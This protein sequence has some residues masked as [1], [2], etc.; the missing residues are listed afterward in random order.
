MSPIFVINKYLEK[1]S[2]LVKPN[3]KYSYLDADIINRK[4]TNIL[5]KLPVDSSDNFDTI[6]YSE[7]GNTNNTKRFIQFFELYINLEV[8]KHTGISYSEFKEMSILEMETCIEFV[9]YKT[10]ILNIDVL[11]NIDDTN[12]PNFNEGLYG[13]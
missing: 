7:R 3:I 10:S 12:I 6:S 5:L 8:Y 1:I 4:I 11:E 9:S 13:R 2:E